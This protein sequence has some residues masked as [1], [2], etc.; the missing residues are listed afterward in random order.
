MKHQNLPELPRTMCI[1][2]GCGVPARI[3][4]LEHESF[5][6]EMISATNGGI[7]PFV[8]IDPA[9]IEMLD[10]GSSNGA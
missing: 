7:P 1:K 10:M 9:N 6:A 5:A 2:P 3:A 8:D 4:C